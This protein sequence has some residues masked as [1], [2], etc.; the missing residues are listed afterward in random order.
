[1]PV[2]DGVMNGATQTPS[3]F[4]GLS[5]TGTLVYLPGTAST[6]STRLVR[7]TREGKA[8]VLSEVTGM[9]WFPRFSPDGT[10]VA[11][12]VSD[13]GSLGGSSDLWVIDVARGA[14]TRITFAGN[15]RFYPIWTRDGA[16][17]T[18]GD[19]TANANHVMWAPAD[20]SGKAEVLMDTGP[21]RFPSSWSPDG[22]TLAFY[23]G[24][25]GTSTN[26]RDLW[27]LHLD[28]DKRT[29]APFVETPF[30]ERGAIFSPNGHWVAYVSNK[31][32]MNDIYARP[33]PGPGGE[34]TISVGGGQEPVWAPSGREMF[35][36]HDG[37]LVAVSIAESG[38]SLTVGSP[39]TVFTDPY[40]L[41]TGGAN[42]GM[43]N[44]DVSPDGKQFVM[45]EEPK[46]ASQTTARLQVV[47]NWFDELKAR[48]PTGR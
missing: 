29:T 45:V 32:G 28:G 15:N 23:V 36:R 12:G 6:S 18:F 4:V 11:Y 43:A 24:P 44:Y 20:G 35:Y 17:L 33:Y 42:G 47:L 38:S 48:V 39:A 27:L 1:V 22:R 25:A 8:V 13:D 30:E 3:A 10:H 26:S 19:A 46:A 40:R 7:M 16:R 5:Q 9:A 2:L 31:S 34:V 14:R 21:R 41:D 37:K